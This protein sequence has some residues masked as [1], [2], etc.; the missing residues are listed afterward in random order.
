MFGHRLT[1]VR[2]GVC[3]CAG[4]VS[5][6]G[7][8]DL[9]WPDC[10]RGLAKT[11]RLQHHQ[12]TFASLPSS[13]VRL[14]K[15]PPAEARGNRRAPCASRW[16][17]WKSPSIS[18]LV[19]DYGWR[20]CVQCVQ[21]S[22]DA[23]ESDGLEGLLRS[24]ENLELRTVSIHCVSRNTPAAALKLLLTMPDALR[25]HVTLWYPASIAS[26]P[27]LGCGGPSARSRAL[28]AP[29]AQSLPVRAKAPTPSN[30]TQQITLSPHYS[31]HPSGNYTASAR[32]PTR[33]TRPTLR[34]CRQTPTPSPSRPRPAT[35]CANASGKTCQQRHCS[36]QHPATHVRQ[37]SG[38][39][40]ITS[41]ISG[42]SPA[43]TCLPPVR[44]TPDPNLGI[45]AINKLRLTPRLPRPQPLRSRLRLNLFK[46]SLSNPLGTVPNTK[47]CD[48]L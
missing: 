17:L 40:F 30:T 28:P 26:R 34:Y 39:G 6:S 47:S 13:T 45:A 7:F 5:C 35:P 32:H 18:A 31:T 9:L 46:D 33:P 2:V 29:R 22:P 25:V 44:D 19:P 14:A 4:W 12:S 8:C 27:A 1:G 24:K 38:C 48:F 36:S 10:S 3:H 41:T 15:T 21:G 20:G 37:R 43:I 42:P 23:L 16:L 11:S